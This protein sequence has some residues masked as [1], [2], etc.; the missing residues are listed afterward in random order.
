MPRV[1]ECSEK[2]TARLRLLLEGAQGFVRHEMYDAPATYLPG[3]ERE[4]HAYG[5]L[6][7]AL[8]TGLLLEPNA[9]AEQILANLLGCL[10]RDGDL[11]GEQE[12]L[13]HLLEQM[14]EIEV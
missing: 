9:E 10:E 3:L 1:L 12:A 14:R 4:D 7:E 2:E 11:K 13:A 6:L 5:D 8:D